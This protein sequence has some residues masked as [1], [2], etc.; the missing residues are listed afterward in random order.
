MMSVLRKFT[1]GFGVVS[2]SILFQLP[3]LAKCPISDGGTLVVRAPVGNLRVDTTGHGAVDVSLSS[4]DIALK[5]TCSKDRAEY[6]ADPGPI[7]GTINWTIVVPR[8]VALDLVTYG[9]SIT[10]GDSDAP[11]TLRTTAGSVTIGNVKGKTAIVTQGGFIK[12][13]TI[14]DSAELRIS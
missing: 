13:G 8:T 10:M 11:V 4:T 6:T 3:A 12:A 9:G 5:E 2:A 1:I 7:R 14:G